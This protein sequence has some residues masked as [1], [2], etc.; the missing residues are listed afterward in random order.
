MSNYTRELNLCC[1]SSRK[2]NKISKS[3]TLPTKNRSYFEILGLMLETVKGNGA[4]KYSIQTRV[5]I[6]NA[7]LKKY[8][9][10]LIERGFIEMRTQ[11]GIVIYRITEEGLAFLRQFYVLFGILLS[12]YKTDQSAL[13]MKQNVIYSTY[14]EIPQHNL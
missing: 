10:F 8:L 6:N 7:Q 13:L 1:F 5:G 9:G 4:A 12:T 14:N 2:R 3:P 11:K